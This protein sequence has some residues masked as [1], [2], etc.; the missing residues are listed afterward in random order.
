MEGFQ[1]VVGLRAIL[2]FIISTCSY[3]NIA[4]VVLN[5]NKSRNAKL[6]VI[7]SLWICLNVY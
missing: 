3:A 6:F 4:S 5:N 7:I 2:I 1:R